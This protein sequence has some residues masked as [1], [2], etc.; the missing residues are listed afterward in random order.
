MLPGRIPGAD[1]GLAFAVF[2]RACAG[3]HNSGEFCYKT[4]GQ[5]WA[6]SSG[7]I[8]PDHRIN[9]ISL[10]SI[11]NPDTFDI[12]LSVNSAQEF[13]CFTLGTFH[14]GKFIGSQTIWIGLML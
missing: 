14:L 4:M 1:V 2:A 5:V 12:I 6:V 9:F 8:I 7:G 3:D 13:Q 10:A 11:P